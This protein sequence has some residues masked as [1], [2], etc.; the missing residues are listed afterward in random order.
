MTPNAGKCYQIKVGGQVKSNEIEIEN[1]IIFYK[2][3]WKNILY[4]SSLRYQKTN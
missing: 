4:K 3:P 1:E 2:V